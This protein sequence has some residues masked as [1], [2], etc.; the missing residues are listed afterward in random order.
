M[1]TGTMS[2]AWARVDRV[3]SSADRLERFMKVEESDKT[4]PDTIYLVGNELH[5][6][7]RH[8]FIAWMRFKHP[9]IMRWVDRFHHDDINDWK[10]E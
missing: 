6:L 3:R 7:W 9:R 10:E 1:E 5:I 8:A 2:K 4:A